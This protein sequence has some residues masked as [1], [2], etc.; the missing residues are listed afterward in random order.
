MIE[1]SR[2][3][4]AKFKYDDTYIFSSCELSCPGEPT[5]RL[6]YAREVYEAF[7]E[8]KYLRSENTRLRAQ[9]DYTAN[10]ER[11]VGR[12]KVELCEI[13][14]GLFYDSEGELSPAETAKV[15]V[16][17]KNILLKR[18]EKAEAA[19]KDIASYCDAGSCVGAEMAA[20]IANRYFD[21]GEAT[22]GS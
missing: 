20:D 16:E 19:L 9:D 18:L 13:N 10:L 5:H 14:D 17:Q 4:K 12:L 15:L 21:D 8:L 1:R 6:L 11:E 3:S 22:N 2:Y 7:D